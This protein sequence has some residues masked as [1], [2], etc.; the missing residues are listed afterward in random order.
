MFI[1]GSRRTGIILREARSF[2]EDEDIRCAGSGNMKQADLV[3]S[4]NE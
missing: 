4:I 1:N 2:E 3:L